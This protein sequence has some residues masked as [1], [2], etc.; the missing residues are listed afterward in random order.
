MSNTTH[1]SYLKGCSIDNLAMDI[2][3]QA[4]VLFPNR[5]DAT[6]FMKLFSEV[7]ELAENLTAGELADVLI[8]L[9]DFGSRKGWAIELAI[10]E[11]MAVNA[12]RK[13]QS[14]SLGVFKHV[15]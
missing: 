9:L 10:R 2:E 6:M 5:T 13:W 3:N 1:L 11:K 8:M 12:C 14:N 7:G 15:E 4:N